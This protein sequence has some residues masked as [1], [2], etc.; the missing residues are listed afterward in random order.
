M[1]YNS[2]KFT[3]KICGRNQMNIYTNWLS[4]KKFINNS[5][6]T[7][8]IFYNKTIINKK[9][10]TC[11]YYS[12]SCFMK[13]FFICEED[14]C[15][16]FGFCNSKVVASFFLW[17]LFVISMIVVFIADVLMLLVVICAR[18]S[19]PLILSKK[20]FD[21]WK[22]YLKCD[23][24]IVKGVLL[25]LL[26]IILFPFIILY[27]V[28][29]G[30]L[31]ILVFMWIDVCGYLCCKKNQY[32]FVYSYIN[33]NNIYQGTINASNKT[34][35]WNHCEGITENDLIQRG[36]SLFTCPN[37]N[38]HSN[39]FKEFINNYSTIDN[40]NGNNGNNDTHNDLNITREFDINNNISIMFFSTDQSIHYSVVCKLTDTFEKIEKKLIQEHPDLQNKRLNYLFHGQVLTNKHKTLAQLKMKNADIIIFNE[41]YV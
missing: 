6:Q 19:I 11:R 21:C 5:K 24:T 36:N 38:N 20:L 29:F 23:T 33:H 4:R 30:L 18:E 28:L 31:Y 26:S 9:Q 32:K 27:V 37:C 17:P 7:Q 14:K 15:L 41:A 40:N 39:T 10:L 35:I 34:D 16:P 25:F 12:K 22:K 2:G 1:E 3:C 8:W 13:P